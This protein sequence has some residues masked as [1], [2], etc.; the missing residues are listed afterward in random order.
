MEVVHEEA[1]SILH[2]HQSPPLP[3]GA[4]DRIEAIVTEADKSLARM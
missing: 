3:A 1:L 2:N 4:A